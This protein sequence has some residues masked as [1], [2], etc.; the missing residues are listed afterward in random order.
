MRRMPFHT[1]ER[2]PV[3]RRRVDLTLRLASTAFPIGVLAVCVWMVLDA[4]ARHALLEFILF[5]TV[6]P[7]APAEGD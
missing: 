5:H 4:N 2:Q 7:M 3:V 6:H 1:P